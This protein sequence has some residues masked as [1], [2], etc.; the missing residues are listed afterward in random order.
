HASATA[1]AQMNGHA[2]ATAKS[3]G[4][5]EANSFLGN[6]TAV[7]VT[8]ADA[9][10]DANAEGSI[11]DAVASRDGAAAAEA[12]DDNST[13]TAIA[14]KDGAAEA[15]VF[16]GTGSTV[17][18]VA[19]KDGAAEAFCDDPAQPNCTETVKATNDG[20]A[21]GSDEGS[22]RAKCDVSGTKHGTAKVTGTGGDCKA[23]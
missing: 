5:A 20:A 16:F 11:C 13:A 14:D 3:G 7:G 9:T 19:V 8:N 21:V 10:C 23:P 12:N 4:T 22:T 6:A 2:K 17:K 18:A 1:N 15:D